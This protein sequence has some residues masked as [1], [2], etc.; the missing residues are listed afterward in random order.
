MRGLESACWEIGLTHSHIERASRRF[1][2]ITI[3]ILSHSV[4]DLFFLVYTKKNT[5]T[6]NILE[7]CSILLISGALTA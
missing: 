7:P 1:I 2:Q 3:L 4:A 6:L 5:E